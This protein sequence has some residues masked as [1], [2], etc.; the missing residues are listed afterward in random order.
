MAVNVGLPLFFASE[1]VSNRFLAAFRRFMLPGMWSSTFQPLA[2]ES[3]V[4]RALR[5][6]NTHEVTLQELEVEEFRIALLPFA[7]VEDGSLGGV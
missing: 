5:L 2:C 3:V 7:M 4:Q 6:V 1:I